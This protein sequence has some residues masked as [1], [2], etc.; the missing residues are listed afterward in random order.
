M[1]DEAELMAAARDTDEQADSIRDTFAR[2]YADGRA[3]AGAEVERQKLRASIAS[4]GVRDA[5]IF[6]AAGVMIIFAGLV[7][8]L[9][10]L[11]LLLTPPFGPGWATAIVFGS[12][13]FIAAVLLLL[14]KS[15]ITRMKKAVQS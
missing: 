11:V 10:G 4:A 15:R 12:S 14:A 3:Y 13:L 8:L 5:I 1:T 9:V 7:S 6:G 2:L